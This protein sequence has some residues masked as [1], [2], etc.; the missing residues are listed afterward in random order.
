MKCLIEQNEL[1]HYQ[2]VHY[3][4]FNRTILTIQRLFYL[5]LSNFQKNKNSNFKILSTFL[6]SQLLLAFYHSHGL[7]DKQLLIK[8]KSK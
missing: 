3:L 1:H 8:F 6:M 5:I 4:Q 7:I 2:E